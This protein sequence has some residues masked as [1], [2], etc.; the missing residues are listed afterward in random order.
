MGTRVSAPGPKAKAAGSAPARM[1]ADVMRMGRR[2]IGQACSSAS[3]GIKR[4]FSCRSCLV[5]SISSYSF[6]S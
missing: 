5:K 4:L 3:V 2:R 1:A 6:G